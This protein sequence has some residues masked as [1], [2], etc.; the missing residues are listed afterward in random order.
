[1]RGG[2]EAQPRVCCAIVRSGYSYLGVCFNVSYT[3]AHGT[4]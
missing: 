1:M 3:T 4:S 2:G